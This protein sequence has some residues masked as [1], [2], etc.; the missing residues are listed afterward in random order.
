M[1]GDLKSISVNL[2]GLDVKE[3]HFL[4]A[5]FKLSQ[6]R[7]RQYQIIDDKGYA[8]GDFF[9]SDIVIV[10]RDSN[11][12]M[13]QWKKLANETGDCFSK[14]T[15]FLTKD[16][17]D[18]D[19]YPEIKKPLVASKV[20][21]ILDRIEV[22]DNESSA[23]AAI[24]VNNGRAPVS[25]FESF[26]SKHNI[27]VID[28]SLPVRKHL[29][30]ELDKYQCTVDL[31]NS[32]EAGYNLINNNDYS[33]VFLDVV[34]PGMDGH[35]LCKHIKKSKKLR[36]TPIVM[37]TS[38]SSTIDKVKGCL[39]GCDSYLT[40]PVNADKLHEIVNKYLQAKQAIAI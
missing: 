17:L 21:K 3:D 38:N 7:S 33:L 30:H 26:A 16:K 18:T 11:S 10:D 8:F 34:L 12:S 20:L 13:Q 24:L 39:S 15:V 36:D 2:I 6:S 23:K 31:A 19:L 40:K 9:Y 5:I 22:A 29:E 37:L 28:D 32:A 14:A 27:L 35:T 1:V 4:K 25:S